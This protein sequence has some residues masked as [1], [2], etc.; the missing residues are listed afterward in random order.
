MFGQDT[1]HGF[2]H[3]PH[4]DSS[5]LP[6]LLG[7]RVI[8]TWTATHVRQYLP[9]VDRA[10][11]LQHLGAP[12]LDQ[13][14]LDLTGLADAAAAAIGVAAL[15]GRDP[16]VVAA[17]RAAIHVARRQVGTKAV[18][19]ALSCSAQTVRRLATDAP[20]PRFVRAVEGQLRL[21][22]KI[23]TDAAFVSEPTRAAPAR[24]ADEE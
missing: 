23:K 19:T 10:A 3:D 5:N 15:N 1:H 20:D 12:D 13:R 18:A 6:D 4:H 21:R 16:A 24:Q 17:R 14:P 2:G 11:L 7:L 8:G 9:R 22:S